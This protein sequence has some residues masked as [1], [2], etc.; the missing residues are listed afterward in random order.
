MLIIRSQEEAAIPASRSQSGVPTGIRLLTGIRIRRVKCD[1]TKP[2]CHRCM[3]TG[4]VC[5]GPRSLQAIV[6]Q[7]EQP[8]RTNSKSPIFA[9]TISSQPW[10][11]HPGERRAFSFFL[12]QA[13]PTLSGAFDSDLWS[14]LVPRMAE[15]NAVVRYAIFAMAH[16]WEHPVRS[17]REGQVHI[18][19]LTQKHLAALNW[20]S[21]ALS[22]DL[23]HGSY[24]ST[25]DVLMKCILF[26]SLEFQQNNFRAGMRLFHIVFTM[27]AP[28]LTT[29]CLGAQAAPVDDVIRTLM[30]MA[31]R[32]PC[33]I[34]T[35]WDDICVETPLTSSLDDIQAA[36]FRG[37]CTVYAG[38]KDVYLARKSDAQAHIDRLNL[39]QA[40]TKR[41]LRT[42]KDY[43]TESTEAKGRSSCSRPSALKDY[44]N[45]ALSWIDLLANTSHLSCNTSVEFLNLIL[46]HTRAIESQSDTLYPHAASTTF[47][48]EIIVRPP[49][50]LVAVFAPNTHLRATALAMLGQTKAGSNTRLHAIVMSLEGAIVDSADSAF[51]NMV[52]VY[53]RQTD[54]P[55][56]LH[57]VYHI[58]MLSPEPI[59]QPPEPLFAEPIQTLNKLAT[60]TSYQ[61][62][63]L[64]EVVEQAASAI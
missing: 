14:V 20:Q 11:T 15:S 2:R 41:I 43:L 49:A 8:H 7:Y 6:F 50:Y 47:S 64:S 60:Y 35:S 12:Q 56:V 61:T 32:S 38:L 29:G 21:K 25:S 18:H 53:H 45:I 58:P 33:L 10:L 19:P 62:K 44:C 17:I 57:K 63:N 1:E 48:H 30:P 55:Q 22:T 46:Q 37:L 3:N 59:W 36:V 4:R 16:F 26:L 9:H 54:Q 5:D 34:F 13:V 28:H 27:L 39:K 40:Q 24:D 51:E 42:L 31:M 52:Q 23:V